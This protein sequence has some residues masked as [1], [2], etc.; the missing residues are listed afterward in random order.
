M[1]ILG[2]EINVKDY[3]CSFNPNL[4]EYRKPVFNL[5]VQ[6]ENRCNAKCDFCNYGKI[7]SNFDYDKLNYIL[8]HLFKEQI[9]KRISLTGGEPLLNTRKLLEIIKISNQYNLP[10]V[11]NSNGFDIL[12]LREIYDFVD[13]ILLTQC[14][15]F[16]LGCRHWLVDMASYI[17]QPY[18]SALS[19][20]V[21]GHS[22][23]DGFSS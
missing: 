15:K 4:Y 23:Q 11:L 18:I 2:K 19:V 20:Q 22:S 14:S 8:E 21:G 1:E 17:L 13:E 5:Y 3:D 9:I 12:K 10:I 16:L 6:T 7:C